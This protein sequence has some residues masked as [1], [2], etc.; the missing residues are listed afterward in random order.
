MSYARIE[1]NSV[2]EYPLEEGTIKTRFSN[3]SF[4]TPFV[5][6]SGYVQ[7]INSLQ[8]EIDYTQNIKE[9]TPVSLDGTWTQSW[10]VT[11]ATP[12]QITERTSRQ[13]QAV[14]MRRTRLLSESDWTQ[15]P[16]S[17]LDAETKLA[18]RICR[19]ALRMVP[20]QTGFPWDVEWPEQP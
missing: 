5:P 13:A 3:T 4:P 10:D 20:E 18:W 15:L 1:N 17:P 6:P 11:D 14:R 12:E 9:G 19:E 2:M 16:D 7:V 8:P